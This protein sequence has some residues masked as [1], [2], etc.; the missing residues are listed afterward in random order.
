[1]KKLTFPAF[2]ILATS[3]LF[4]SCATVD[5]INEL[6]A[7]MNKKIETSTSNKNQAKPTNH[8]VLFSDLPFC[9]KCSFRQR[10]HL[11]GLLLSCRMALTYPVGAIVPLLIGEGGEGGVRGGSG[12]GGHMYTHS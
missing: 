8:L 9:K 4:S 7:N 10:Y 11:S 2:T 1:M 3:L 5:K 6:S 12:W